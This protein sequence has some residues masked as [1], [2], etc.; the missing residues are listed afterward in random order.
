MITRKNIQNYDAA[1]S[2]DWADEKHDYCLWDA[3]TNS[4]ELGSMQNRP[5]VIH[6]FI[7]K[8]RFRFQGRKVA[9]GLEQ[10][11][12]ALAY[13]LMEYGFFTIYFVHP[14]TVAKVREAWTPS[15]AKDDPGDAELI[16][17][18]VR[19]SNH[20]LRAWKPDTPET[21][22]LML[23]CSHRRKLV[24]LRVKLTNM[25]RSC[26]KTYYPLACLVTGD[27]LNEPLALNFL[28][29]WPTFESL[30]RSRISTVEKYYSRGNSRSSKVILERLEIIRNA[31]PATTDPVITESYSM[32]ML[33]L[34]AQIRQL[35]ETI[36]LYDKEIYKTYCSHSDV[37]IINSF[38]ATGKVFGPRLIAALGTDRER[39][40]SAHE[41]E[42]YSGIAPVVDRSG[43]TAKIYRRYK[44]SSFIRQSF[45]EW[46]N[47]TTKHCLWA[48]A[49]YVQGREKGMG[50]HQAVRSLA[51]KWIRII[52]KCWKEQIPYDDGHYMSM[53]KK[54]G[55]GLMKIIAEHPDV[56]RLNGPVRVQF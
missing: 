11:K 54:R 41:I 52:Y 16:M 32:Q 37:E 42:C 13:Q 46:A 5:E 47:E 56:Y 7:C 24:D 17:S 40:E 30:K 18:I 35:R 20:K 48:R 39:F 29:R 12:G 50:H 49:F 14:T 10:S 23:L 44:C 55:S 4:I 36:K 21:H 3:E 8:I 43:K 34:V 51:Y 1:L 53:L 38:P 27:K 22:R 19:D 33:A 9:V 26:L 31:E 28:T 45:H 15:G 6:D 25:L 2:F